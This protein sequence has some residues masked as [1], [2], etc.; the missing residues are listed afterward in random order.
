MALAGLAFIGYAVLFFVRNFTGAFLE[1]GIGPNE[2]GV[3]RDELRAL[4]VGLYT[5]RTCP[6]P[7]PASSPP[8]AGPPRLW[9]GS[10]CAGVRS[11]RA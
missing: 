8:P 3:N 4:D 11:G 10:E 6:S 1:L 2:V 7:S 5:S 9:R